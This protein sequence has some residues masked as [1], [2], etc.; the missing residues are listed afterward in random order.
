[1][2][3]A[4][5]CSML[6]D[7]LASPI[8]VFILISV[9]N[10]LTDPGM[11]LFVDPWQMHINESLALIAYSPYHAS[12]K[13]IT[14]AIFLQES[15]GI[16]MPEKRG[17]DTNSGTV[18]DHTCQ[19]KVKPSR[20]FVVAEDEL[21]S[22][23]PLRNHREIRLLELFPGRDE[24]PLEGIIHHV[25]VDS[26]G[27]Y[28]AISYVWGPHPKPFYFQ[29]GEGKI[30]ITVSLHGA[31]RCIRDR[32]VSTLL[33]ADAICIDQEKCLEKSIQIRLMKT[34]FQSAEGI[35]AWLG[36]E[37]DNSDRAIETLLQIRTTTLK[38]DVWPDGLPAVPLS[39]TGRKIPS[40]TDN[41]WEDIN[42][43]LRRDWFRRSWIVQEL[44]LASN[45]MILCGRWT[46]NWDDFF[47]AVKICRDGIQLEMHSN[48]KQGLMLGYSDPA[49][50]LG[51]TRQSRLKLDDV[52]F[53]RRYNLL[54]LLDLFAYTKAT[55]ERDK[56]FALLGLASDCHG[57]AFDPDYESTMDAIVRRYANEFVQRGHAMD[58]L[59]RAG[60]SKSYPFCSWIPFWTRENFPKT[61]SSWRGAGGNFCAGGRGRP[62]AHLDPINP[63]T[64]VVRGCLFDTIV[65]MSDTK[66]DKND[67]IS[68][69]NSIHASI[70]LIK[71]Y[72][73]GE[74]R[75]DLKLNLPVGSAGR[76]YLEPTK[77]FVPQQIIAAAESERVGWLSGLRDK[78]SSIGSTQEMMNFLKRP[79]DARE[80]V[81]KYWQTAAAFASRIS[82][83]T[84][85]VTKI[86]YV[87]LVPGDGQVG[88]KVCIFGG[89]AVP[90]VLRKESS[91]EM[92]RLI[93]EGYIHGLMYGEAFSFKHIH[94]QDFRIV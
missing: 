52:I 12:F 75:Q 47:E 57:K 34:I 42:L 26:P 25:S 9:Y 19:K 36:E 54:E 6:R 76:P 90:F 77:G 37:K 60:T 15:P 45:V 58:L 32:E 66:P 71:R 56:L 39:W 89:G 55:Q 1:M 88:D 35:I 13:D 3:Q 10:I 41:A 86:G 18:S 62:C 59:Y 30:P 11:A 87:G 69:V 23:Q 81:W 49:Y 83:G 22:Y 43:L 74:S 28:W 93:G 78:I 2:R 38:P 92:Y 68:F 53:G 24:M 7:K 8:E 21:F 63:Y 14:S 20:N 64:L 16:R 33:W 79:Q 40:V 67:I 70:N 50:V 31:L 61:I 27:E 4:Q 44:I 51:L 73:T 5:D 17:I 84:F 82:N 46:L 91:G 72:P 85:C 94:E 80:V 65:Q 29:T 48:P